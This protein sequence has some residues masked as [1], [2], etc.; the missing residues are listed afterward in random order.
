[1]ISGDEKLTDV[2]FS[3]AGSSEYGGDCSCDDCCVDGRHEG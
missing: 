1:M 3:I 2:I